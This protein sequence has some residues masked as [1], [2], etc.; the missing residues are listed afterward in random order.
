LAVAA[1]LVGLWG[2]YWLWREARPLYKAKAQRINCVNILKQIGLAFR[3]WAGDDSDQ[4]PFN[5]STNAGGTLEFCAREADGFD[6]NGWLHLLVLSNELNTPKVLVCPQDRR[7]KAATN[8]NSL[9]AE[10]VTY[11]LRS[12][13]EV[14]ETN[15]QAVLAVCPIEGNTVFCDG[16]VVEGETLRG[17]R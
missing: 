17:K 14:N 9:R 3:I 7:R 8:F 5:L 16:T 2:A 12:G 15:A 6:W 13:A 4:Y 10:H 1:L 11:R